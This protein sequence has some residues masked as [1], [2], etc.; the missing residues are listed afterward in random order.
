VTS[1]PRG[2]RNN[3]PGNIR[4]SATKWQGLADVQDD[5]DFCRF[6]APRWGIRA[7]ARLMLTYSSQYGLRS[8]R[9]LVE[10]WAPRSENNTDAYVVAVASGVGV[11][12]GA[13]IDVDQADVM[14]ALIKAIILHENG[15]NPYS[16]AVIAEA[17]HLAGVADAKPAPLATQHSFQAQIGAAVAVAGAA[18]AHVAQYAPTVKGWADQLSDFTGSPVIQ[19]AVTI[20]LTIDGGLTL[21]G[22]ASQIL[23]QRTA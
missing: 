23:K 15:Q 2:I 3:N 4:R 16:D 22:I 9:G 20:L 8:V 14:L 21:V 7:I 18:G 13:E 17:I 1:Q 5:R 6:T 11:D 10:R 12:P 19:H